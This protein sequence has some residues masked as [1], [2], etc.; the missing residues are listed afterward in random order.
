MA[1]KRTKTEMNWMREDVASYLIRVN[2]DPHKAWDLYIIENLGK[3][4]EYYI[5]GIKDFILVSKELEV[6]RKRE[7]AERKSKL[8]AKQNRE[9]IISEL[10]SLTRNDVKILWKENKD[11]VTQNEKL[12]LVDIVNIIASG[13]TECLKDIEEQHIKLYSKLLL[14]PA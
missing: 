14:Q 3:L 5:K 7:E 6:E 4:R 2:N 8:E 10:K 1:K 9:K 12:I 13:D 11:K